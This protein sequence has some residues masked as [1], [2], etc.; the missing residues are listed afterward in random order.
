M[1][2]MILS[3]M[4][5]HRN[6]NEENHMKYLIFGTGE[7]YSRY[8]KWFAK[9]DIVALID[10]AVV[11]QNTYLDGIK[12]LSP[13][14]GVKLAY[15]AV[16]IL[17]FYVKDMR[18]QL[19]ELGVPA[20]K[21][22][23]FYDLHQLIC[24]KEDGQAIDYKKPIEY[25]GGAE[26]VEKSSCTLLLS[27]DLTLG[28]PAIA[29]YHMARVLMD[30]GDKVVFASTLDGPLRDILVSEGI[31]V[32]VDVNLQ[33]E[34]MR[35]AKWTAGFARMVCNT[36]NFYVFLS[37]RDTKI[38]VVW[39]MHDSLFFYD[40]IDKKIL[41]GVNRENLQIYA[42]GPVAGSAIAGFLPDMKIGNLIYGVAD[43]ASS[44]VSKI[45]EDEKIRFI[46]I[47]YIEA[48]KGQD[49][50]VRAIEKLP[51]EMRK[52]AE[53]YLVGQNTSQMAGEIRET[54]SDI[55]EVIMTGTMD[56]KGIHEMLS[57]ADAMICP[58]REDPMPTVAAEAMMHK[59]PCIVSDA[60]G[61][62]AYICSGVDGIVFSSEDERELTEKIIWCIKHRD[63]L[64]DMGTR[65]REIYDKQFSMT[66]FE[67]KVREI[68]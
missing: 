10:N 54:I 7:Y 43:E 1:Q 64:S 67:R 15:D 3:Y 40:G 52:R 8:K 26:N 59:V 2:D 4:Q 23:H 53:F 65:A 63:K 22:Y 46:T 47:G 37:D 27:H 29:L 57:R 9:E 55:P 48:R 60:T 39:W 50:L 45:H 21:I 18:R 61:T 30:G 58:S 41:G 13:N 34:T 38:P 24:C 14:Q 19:I 31:P 5:S 51:V 49:I 11:K 16:M 17:S 33:I 62:A 32:I 42:V 12:I 66:A 25:Y 28:G 35:E 20:E 36:I 6:Q 44:D 68:V 56:R